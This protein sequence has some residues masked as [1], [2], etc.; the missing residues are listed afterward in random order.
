MKILL[1]GFEPFGGDSMNPS[2]EAVS[3]LPDTLYGADILKVRLPVEY[4]TV[5]DI[6][7]CIMEKETPDAVICVG[8]A[9][10]RATITPE[11]VAINWMDASIPDAKNVLATGEPVSL[12]GET[13]FFSTL[14]VKAIVSALQ[15]AGVPASLSFTAGTY[16]CNSTMYHLLDL[17]TE[18]GLGIPAGFV[19]VPFICEQTVGRGPNTPSLPLDTLVKGLTEMV[20][21]IVAGEPTG[22]KQP[23]GYT[24]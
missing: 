4:H 1:T 7:E 22:G 15:S 3:R 10:G 24:H 23:S 18:L 16:V 11:M 6:L 13:A 12:Y 9:G 5:R 17:T 20:R 2:W 8:Q 21:V 14:P 19:H